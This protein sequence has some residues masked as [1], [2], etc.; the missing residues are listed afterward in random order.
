MT[1]EELQKNVQEVLSNIDNVAEV[2]KKLNTLQVEIAK[3]ITTKETLET[4]KTNMTKTIADLKQSN[5]ELFC[6]IPVSNDTISKD[7]EEGKKEE[8][9][10]IDLSQLGE[11]FLK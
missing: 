8:N 7:K 11:E 1:I 6:R 4:E 10:T 9:E 3:D 5:Y 2:S